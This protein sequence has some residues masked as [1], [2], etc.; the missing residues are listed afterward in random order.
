VGATETEVPSFE[1][2]SIPAGDNCAVLRVIGE[3]E[4]Y[5]APELRERVIQLLA[6]GAIH[7]IADLRDVDFLDSTGLGALVGSL[8]RVRTY[9]GSL[10]LVAS[11]ARIREI[12]T[13]TGLIN[14]FLLYPSI[15]QAIAASEDWITAIAS[16]GGSAEDWC[17]KHGLA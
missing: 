9:D 2:E 17:R 11:S 7:L 13:I 12:F 8:R 4:V 1:L 6:G 14:A 15:P 5:T 16:E 3:V 10:L